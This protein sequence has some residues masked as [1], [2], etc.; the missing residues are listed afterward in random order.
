MFKDYKINDEAGLEAIRPSG[1][2]VLIR[3]LTETELKTKAEW[4]PKLN[5]AENNTFNDVIFWM[6]R[7]VR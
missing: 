2:P 4:L 1:N 5:Q 7:N 6:A 3:Y